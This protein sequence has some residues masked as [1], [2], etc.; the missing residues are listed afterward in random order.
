MKKNYNLIKTVDG[1]DTVVGSFENQDV[2]EMAC[3]VANRRSQQIES[4]KSRFPEHIFSQRKHSQ[5]K[6]RVQESVVDDQLYGTV[7][8]QVPTLASVKKEIYSNKRKN[9]DR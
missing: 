1:S 6:Y 7:L 3:V 9:E 8:S 5:A 4:Y 2:A